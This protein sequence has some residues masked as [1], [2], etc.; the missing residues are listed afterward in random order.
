METADKNIPPH[1]D[2]QNIYETSIYLEKHL[3]DYYVNLL[4][5]QVGWILKDI[6]CC[7]H[8]QYPLST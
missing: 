5:H 4:C 3:T 8:V 2:V 6:L 1:T 7:I